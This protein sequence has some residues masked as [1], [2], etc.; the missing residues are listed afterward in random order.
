MS[1]IP[2]NSAMLVRY[3]MG[4]LESAEQER[5]EEEY[6]C[7]DELFIKLLD[8][9][10]QLTSDYLSGRL[11]PAD[12]ERFVQHFLSTAD[13]WLE[14]ELEGFLQS[15]PSENY[16]SSQSDTK[17]NSKSDGQ[18]LFSFPK[19]NWLLAGAAAAIL[20]LA[21]GIWFWADLFSPSESNRPVTGQMSTATASKP[22]IL[23]L[24]RKTN[25]RRSGG[26]GIPTAQL[27]QETQS[28]TLQIEV[29]EEIYPQYQANLQ[30]VDEVTNVLTEKGLKAETIAGKAP[31]VPLTVPA[32]KLPIGDYQV[33]LSGVNPNDS[34]SF[35]GEYHFWVRGP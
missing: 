2:N 34:L 6:F 10:D 31:M 3:L 8:V 33:Q 32:S 14:V 5:L 19:L 26:S 1:E 25:P 9:R 23:F 20:L 30:R 27:T 21:G 13:G 12:R 15:T 22:F 35:I 11:D 16:L 7:N 4:D 17:Q 24:P 29:G 28:V 18:G